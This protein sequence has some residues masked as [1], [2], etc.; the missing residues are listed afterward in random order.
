[1]VS[2]IIDEQESEDNKADLSEAEIQEIERRYQAIQS[3]LERIDKEKQSEQ[4]NSDQ[5]KP[6]EQAVYVRDR[7]RSENESTFSYSSILII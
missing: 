1:M 6:K 2:S 5:Q 3:E 7:S 4:Q